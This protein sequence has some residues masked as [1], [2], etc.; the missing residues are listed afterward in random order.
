[1]P[2]KLVS[3]SLRSVCMDV[4]GIKVQYKIGE[5]VKP[6]VEGSHLFVFDTIQSVKNFI[7]N[8][9][10]FK[11]CKVYEVEIK[12]SRKIRQPLFFY[13]CMRFDRWFLYCA[14]LRKN[15]KKYTDKIDMN[16]PRGTIFADEVKLVKEVLI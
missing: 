6:N 9:L 13:D 4:S 1:M 10:S 5:W 14:K 7:G 3:P 2:Y 16:Y 8:R 15:H 12:A 11:S